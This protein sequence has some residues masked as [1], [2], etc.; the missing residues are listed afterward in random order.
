MD[1]V[2]EDPRI[3]PLHVSLFTALL[4][5][6]CRQGGNAVAVSARVLK[7]LAK[8]RGDGP[9]H[10]S[11]RQLHAYGYLTYLPSFDRRIP[12]KVILHSG[13]RDQSV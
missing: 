6:S 7:P 9:Y 10:R 3:G 11:M 8:I 13:G 2:V 5:L 4:Y 1:R 12:S